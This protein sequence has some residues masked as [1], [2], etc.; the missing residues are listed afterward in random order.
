M[1][2]RGARVSVDELVGWS[3]K[4]AQWDVALAGTGSSRMY[5]MLERPREER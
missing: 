3:A 2:A 4:D 5:R 1:A